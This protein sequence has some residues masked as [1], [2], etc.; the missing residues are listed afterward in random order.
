MFL[1]NSMSTATYDIDI[2]NKDEVTFVCCSLCLWK[3]M[4]LKFM[5]CDIYKVELQST[6]NNLVLG[7]H[8]QKYG[9]PMV[10]S[11]NV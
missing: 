1:A 10:I 3:I 8:I 4:F 7:L 11:R 6:S 2:V 9:G 5:Y